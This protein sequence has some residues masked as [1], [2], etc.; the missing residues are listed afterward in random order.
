M[1]A[2]SSTLLAAEL[3]DCVQV[4]LA[5]I[6][7]G[8]H[9]QDPLALGARLG[10]TPRPDPS[11]LPTVEPGLE[12]QLRSAREL[13]GL[14]VTDRR[15][16]AGSPSPPD[17]LGRHRG[18]Y[19]VADAFHLPWVPYYGH[20]HMEHSFLLEPGEDDVTVRDAYHNDTA[21]GPAR[22]GSWPLSARQL[23]QALPD[24]ALVLAFDR[25]PVDAPRPDVRAA[26]PGVVADYL[27]A[28][29]E[30]PDRSAALGQLTL[31]TWLLA[32]SR[33]LHAAFREDE[34]PSPAV[35]EHL[36]AWTRLVEQTYLAYRRVQRGRAEPDGPLERLAEQLAADAAV[37]GAG[38]TGSAP[39]P[40]TDPDQELR[41]AVAEEAGAVLRAPAGE[42]LGGAE[43][44]SFP[45]FS[46]FRMVEIV[47]RLEERLGI[48]MAPEDLVPENLRDVDT[49]CRTV[50]RS[51]KEF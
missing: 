11:G 48:E 24:G 13:L 8:D 39:A 2:D 5:L 34:G 4:N 16:L 12:D 22:P 18:V 44:R 25:V 51:S 35:R 30:H 49:L 23:A 21:W 46:S 45:A 43:L 47:E 9:G 1:N 32:R 37:F 33:R 17:V 28:Y 27:R 50:R 20:Q 26:E 10:F 40:D 38:P 7:D 41:A 6:A 31:E 42:L 19:V 15:S 3:Y 29:R 14:A 36:D